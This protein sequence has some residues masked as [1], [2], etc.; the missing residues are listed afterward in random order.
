MNTPRR[1]I[2]PMKMKKFLIFN[3]MDISFAIKFVLSFSVYLSFYFSFLKFLRRY[4]YFSSLTCYCYFSQ[5]SEWTF[6]LQIYFAHFAHFFFMY[7]NFFIFALHSPSTSLLHQ[8]SQHTIYH[9]P[10]YLPDHLLGLPLR[11]FHLPHFFSRHP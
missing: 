9:L 8:I 11:Q 6:Y 10:L 5:F 1:K 4:I 7:I 3:S 2:L